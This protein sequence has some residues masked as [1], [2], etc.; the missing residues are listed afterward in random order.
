MMVNPNSPWRSSSYQT[1]INAMS[2]AELDMR[3]ADKQKQGFVVVKRHNYYA[4]HGIR[5]YIAVVRK[6]S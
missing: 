5:K 2:E 6:V 4:G 3:I 1:T